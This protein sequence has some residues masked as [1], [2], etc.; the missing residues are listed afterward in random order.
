MPWDNTAERAYRISQRPVQDT[1][2]A[3]SL[4]THESGLGPAGTKPLKHISNNELCT[5]TELRFA[6]AA[7]T[8]DDHFWFDV[9][10]NAILGDGDLSHVIAGRDVVH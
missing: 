4:S 1:V 8:L 10:E 2:W 3:P 5:T 9:V 6:G 7:V